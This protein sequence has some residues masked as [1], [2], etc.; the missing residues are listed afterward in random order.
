M[1]YNICFLVINIF[2]LILYYSLKNKSFVNPIDSFIGFGDILFFLAITPLFNF[3]P[4]ILFFIIGLIFSL[5]LF[6]VLNAFKKT[7]TVPLAGYF[8]IF[9]IGNLFLKNVLNINPLI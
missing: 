6:G 8:A 9:L 3:K 4:F 1:F 7:E 5:M 2:G